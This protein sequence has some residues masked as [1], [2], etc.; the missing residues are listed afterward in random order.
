[1][2]DWES[3]STIIFLIVLGILVWI[4]R[5]NIDFK[6]GIFMRKIKK[7]KEW[8]YTVGNKYKTFFGYFG[9]VGI[10]IAVISSLVA[11]YF[12]ALQAYII[13]TN[14]KVST[15]GLRPIIPSVPSTVACTYALCVP[16]WFWIIGVLVVLL[17]HELSHAFVSRSAN[18]RIKSFGLISVLILPGAFVEPDER[19]LKKSSSL[20]KLKIYAA[21]SFANL[22]VFAIASLVTTAMFNGF[23]VASGVQYVG[24]VANSPAS[25]IN[26]KGVIKQI[27]SMQISTVQDFENFITKVSPGTPLIIK[28]SEGTYNLTTAKNPDDPNKGFVGIS[29]ASTDFH[30]VERYSSFS[31][32]IDWVFQLFAWLVFLNFGIGLVNLLPIKPLDGGLM[33]EEIIK[34]IFR[35]PKPKYVRAL[36]IF[37]FLL[38]IINIIGPYIPQ[39]LALT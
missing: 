14:P 27:D 23:Y 34:I 29:Q 6:Y 26:L 24:L 13:I 37:T 33:Y 20:T 5:K 25:Q 31:G 2:I 12:I 10:V 1:M 36:S 8:I 4:D 32:G 17:S 19:Q 28:T 3:I 18:I 38:I 21:G 22:L 7:G 16:F 35:K 11:F 39:L 15:P 9:S 30:V